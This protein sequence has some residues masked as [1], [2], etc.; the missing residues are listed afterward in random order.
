[1]LFVQLIA[2]KGDSICFVE[3]FKS[4][5]KLFGKR[6]NGY[7]VKY[8]FERASFQFLKTAQILDLFLLRITILFA[9]REI[10]NDLYIYGPGIQ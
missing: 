3:N 1:M 8:Y 9:K 6:N 2:A 5:T 4:E 7:V 10:C